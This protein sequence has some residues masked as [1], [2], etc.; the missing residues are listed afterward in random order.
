MPADGVAGR[1][2]ACGNGDR[3]GGAD[4]MLVLIAGAK[5]ALDSAI[6]YNC[7]TK[8]APRVSGMTC[9]DRSNLERRRTADIP[10]FRTVEPSRD[11]HE[12]F[13]QNTDRR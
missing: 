7:L 5:D 6:G 2:H 8:P 10:A 1:G 3:P 9:A 12:Q 11:R 4:L 13:S